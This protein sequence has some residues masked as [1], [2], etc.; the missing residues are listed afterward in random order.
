MYVHGSNSGHFHAYMN[1]AHFLRLKVHSWVCSGGLP[2][3]LNFNIIT[4]LTQVIV[5][6]LS[7]LPT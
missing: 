3:K 1:K 2:R 5:F 6:V 4:T 7:V